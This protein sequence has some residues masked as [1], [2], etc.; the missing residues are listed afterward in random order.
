MGVSRFYFTGGEPLLRSDFEELAEYVL[1]DPEAEL[2]VLTN[3][4]LIKDARLEMLQRLDRDRVRL[5]ISLDGA[6]AETNDAIRGPGSTWT[7]GRRVPWWLPERIGLSRFWSPARR[8]VDL[9]AIGRIVAYIV[10]RRVSFE[11]A[12][13]SSGLA[14]GRRP[15]SP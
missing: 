15:S 12:L 2:A 5:Q 7:F 3:G 13:F 10:T 8:P 9:V 6:T 4:I 14:F 1:E 11:F